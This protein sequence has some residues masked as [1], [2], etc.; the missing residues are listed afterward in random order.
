MTP[1]R[2]GDISSYGQLGGRF[3]AGLRREAPGRGPGQTEEARDVGRKNANPDKKLRRRNRK[4]LAVEVVCVV[5]AVVCIA[6]IVWQAG[7][8]IVADQRF[9]EVKE[10]T[11]R[12][13]ERLIELYGDA[14]GW[15]YVDD[16]RID[17]P[18]MYTP[19]D[20]EYY[21]HRNVDGDY[22]FA[23]TPFLGEGSNPEEESTDSM[24]VYA[25][26]MRDG[27]MFG[28]LEKYEEE[29]FAASHDV[30]YLDTEGVHVYHVIAAW[31]EDLSGS[32]Y[33][34]YWDN[35]GT[36]SEEDFDEYVQEAASRSLYQTQW[37]ASY[38]DELLT[39]S[40]CS[41]GTSEE[42]F[43]VVAVRDDDAENESGL[44]L[45]D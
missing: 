4:L 16:T 24:I 18:V 5:V 26:H 20:P 17:Y 33:Y 23:G 35:V 1:G 29:D 39:L 14:V 43:V 10:E 9:E 25:H 36:L 40:T 28:Q 22:S 31:H 37:S 30:Y 38:G 7:K 45:A 12:D 34:R 15:I 11:G 2:G 3:T 21:L 32:S 13:P 42:R 6:V 41:Y 44:K 27:S 19:D 8:Y